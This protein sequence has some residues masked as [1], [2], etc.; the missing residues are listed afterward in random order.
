MVG[1]LLSGPFA[2]S[3]RDRCELYSTSHFI[4]HC[5]VHTEI[6]RSNTHHRADLNY[7][8]FTSRMTDE[9]NDCFTVKCFA[10]LLLTLC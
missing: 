1:G 8:A 4:I 2:D 6:H 10:L 3:L 9:P 7:F 5:I